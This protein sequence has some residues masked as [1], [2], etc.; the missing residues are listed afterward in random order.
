MFVSSTTLLCIY[1]FV[2]SA[3]YIKFTM[4]D[5]NDTVWAALKKS[6]ASGILM[7]YTFIAVWFVGG[8]TV[9][10]SYLVSTNQ[11]T[12]ENFR[13][14]SENRANPYDRGAMN[15]ISEILCT[16]ISPSKINL[17]AKI[18]EQPGERVDASVNTYEECCIEGSRSKIGADIETGLAASMASD[19]LVAAQE[20]SFEGREHYD[21]AFS[22]FVG[23][24]F[25]GNI[26][27]SE[28]SKHSNIIRKNETWE[29]SPE[30]FTMGTIAEQSRHSNGKGPSAGS[31][32]AK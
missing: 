20:I 17:R 19:N 21:D 30:S 27:D 25:S 24:P 26:S 10:H 5:H 4:D 29:I 15:N 12:Y 7:L 8:L 3:L 2:V 6:P 32:Q 18:E 11:T 22:T 1:V 9:F 14:R 31:L 16:K 28:G 23:H 13:Y